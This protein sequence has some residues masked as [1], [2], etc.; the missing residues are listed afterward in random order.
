[1]QELRLNIIK[2]AFGADFL[3]TMK[4][5]LEELS[6]RTDPAAAWHCYSLLVQV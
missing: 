5:T 4:Q 6:K 3:K 1:M 2:Q